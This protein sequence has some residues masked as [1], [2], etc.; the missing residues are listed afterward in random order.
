MLGDW[1]LESKVPC[2]GG[3]EGAG[4][5]VA[6]GDN[7]HEDIKLGDAVGIKW[8]ADSCLSCEQCNKG[9]ESTCAK[10]KCSGFSVDGSF[11]QYAVS[12]ARH[13]T[14]I[15]EGLGLDLA[16][17]ILCAGVTVW[18]AIKAA[19]L[20]PGETIVISGTFHCFNGFDVHFLRERSPSGAGGG[21][22][23][24][25]VQYA[26]AIG[27]RVIAL[28]TGEDKRQLCAKLGAETFIDFATS[29]DIVAD[30]QA[31]T[32]GLGPHAAVVA[33]S[34]AKAYEQALDV[35]SKQLPSPLYDELTAM[36][37]SIYAAVERLSPSAYPQMPM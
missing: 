23:H 30:I 16:A 25:A 28:D 7:T 10:A 31:A 34:G 5:V 9:N 14:P 22:G 17:P 4:Y 2:I 11:Q 21:L 18:K 19:E 8:L 6:I 3:H 32:G 24:L 20:T 1:P 26:N 33:A 37:Y 15:P 29:K 36:I 13:V 12:Y 27:L 35:C